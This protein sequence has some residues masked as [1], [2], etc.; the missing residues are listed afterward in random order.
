MAAGDILFTSWFTPMSPSPG[1]GMVAAEGRAKDWAAYIGTYPMW[2]NN[3]DVSARG[4]A[5]RGARLPEHIALAVWP[6]LADSGL[7]YR[8]QDD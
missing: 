7:K 4:I 3:P 1:I 2:S 6:E 8:R 5:E